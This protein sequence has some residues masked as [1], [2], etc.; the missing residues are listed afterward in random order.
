MTKF[1][2]MTGLVVLALGLGLAARAVSFRVGWGIGWGV[3]LVLVI[4]WWVRALQ[5]P[6]RLEVT[7]EA[8]RYVR[9]D[10]RQAAVLSRRYGDELV[11]VEKRLS[12]GGRQLWL[13][14]PGVTTVAVIPMN[15][16]PRGEVRQA[17]VA[18]R[19]RFDGGSW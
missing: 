12:R 10:G 2:V 19:W 18:R 17:F 15:M 14:Q 4:A 16:F 11:I 5:R 3:V 9:P 13:T 1:G 6:A 7:E 8:V